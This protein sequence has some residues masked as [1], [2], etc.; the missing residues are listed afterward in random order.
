M[1]WVVGWRSLGE[2]VGWVRM[3]VV[4]EW[5]LSSTRWWV[6]VACCMRAA[7]SLPCLAG[8][9]VSRSPSC[10]IPTRPQPLPVFATP[11]SGIKIL[12][13]AGI[14]SLGRY[15]TVAVWVAPP[16]HPTTPLLCRLPSGLVHIGIIRQLGQGS[17][18]QSTIACR[19]PPRLTWGPNWCL[20]TLAS[21]IPSRLATA[22]LGQLASWAPAQAPAPS[23][24]RCTRS[25]LPP[26]SAR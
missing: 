26:T 5:E 14:W 12:V 4:L 16:C 15:T 25:P 1:W 24:R 13:Q 17:G 22:G 18:H 23:P 20:Y 6:T 10:P 11:L 9:G 2:R 8:V 21:H 3:L 7:S 19:L